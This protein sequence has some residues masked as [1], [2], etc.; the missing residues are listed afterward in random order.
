MRYVLVAL[1]AAVGCKSAPTAPPPANQAPAPDYAATA[2]DEL[3]FL[4]SNADFVVGLDMTQLR[5]SQ[6]WHAFEPQI[7]AFMRQAQDQFGGGCGEDFMKKLERFTI[8]LKV[9]PDN[10]V[11]GVIV[12]RGGDMPAALECSAKAAKNSG[13]TA[14]MDRGVLVLTKSGR[15]D[16][17]SAS[18]AINPSTL[19]VHLDKDASHDSLDTALAA[20]VPLRSSPE[21]LKLYERRERGAALWGMANGNASVFEQLASSGLRP[22]TI[23]GTIVATDRLVL[24]I[25]MTMAGTVEATKLVGEIDQVKGMA[26]SYVERIDTRVDGPMVHVEVALTEAQLRSLAGML[27]GMMGP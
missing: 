23:D 21:F 17:A 25:R 7:D 6:L 3:A 8:S 13:K 22:R 27:G 16:L 9:R 10:Q 20:G 1:V 19:V 15:P 14:T 12:M 18:R 24:A 4:S 11:N 5:R 2:N 26:A